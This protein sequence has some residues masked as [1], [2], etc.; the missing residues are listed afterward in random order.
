MKI[1]YYVECPSEYAAGLIGSN[2]IITIKVDSGDPGGE[3]DGE[4]SFKEHMRLAL[5][6]WFDGCSVSVIK[7]E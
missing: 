4:N 1:E 7:G 5:K 3:K 2:D 6:E